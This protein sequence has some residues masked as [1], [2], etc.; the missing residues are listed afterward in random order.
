VRP[1]LTLATANA[2]KARELRALLAGTGYEIRT[3]GDHP[4][5][6]L[7]PEGETS[8]AENARRKAE[9]VATAVGTI[10]L[11]DDSGLEVDVLGGRP[12]PASARY[13]G[14]GL[15]DAARVA[16]LLAQVGAARSC[17]ARFRCV[18]ALAAPWGDVVT[19]EGV[20]E[21]ELVRTSRGVG[22]FGYDPVFLVPELGRT[23]AELPPDEKH[24][25]S[26]RGRAVAL[27]RPILERWACRA[28]PAIEDP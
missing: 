20:L 16:R 8:Y 11:A 1:R 23:L 12:G 22:G 21:G 27:A 10:A 6:A 9:A 5:L 19:V 18:V 2:A 24:R 14:A 17:T 26:H 15:D 13:G 28:D 3:L 7:P 25:V 4:G